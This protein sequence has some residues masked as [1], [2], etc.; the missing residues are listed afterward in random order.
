MS[1]Q[2]DGVLQVVMERFVEQQLPVVLNLEHKVADGVELNN[3]EI[4]LMERLLHEIKDFNRFMVRYPK[5]DDL[6]AKTSSLCAKVTSKALTIEREN[7]A[8]GQTK[9]E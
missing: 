5:Y 1:E 8:Q 2:E 3:I 6:V 7:Q 4:E 9:Q